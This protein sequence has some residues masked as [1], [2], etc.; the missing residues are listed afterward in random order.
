MYILVQPKFYVGKESYLFHIHT[1]YI[2]TSI[3]QLAQDNQDFYVIRDVTNEYTI[4][5]S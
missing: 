2:P 1:P 5:R 3:E 4:S